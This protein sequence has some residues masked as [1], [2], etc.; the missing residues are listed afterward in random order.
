MDR[1]GEIQWADILAITYWEIWKT[2]CDLVFRKVKHNPSGS[3]NRITNMVSCSKRSRRAEYLDTKIQIRTHHKS[4][5]HTLLAVKL[6]IAVS[7]RSHLREGGIALMLSDH[8]RKFFEARCRSFEASTEEDIEEEAASMTILWARQLKQSQV[9]VEGDNV[10]VL[11]AIKI[12]IGKAVKNSHQVHPG[13]NKTFI[14]C[15]RMIKELSLV[16]ESENYL[17]RMLADQCLEH[18]ISSQWKEPQINPLLVR[19]LQDVTATNFGLY[20]QD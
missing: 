15:I 20:L 1:K 10:K 12:Q 16:P 7:V 18:K 17:P 14:L 5:V 8:T 6:N 9:E 11:E 3:G 13:K 4:I 2:R 19:L